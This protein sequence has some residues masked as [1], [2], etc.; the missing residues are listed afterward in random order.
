MKRFNYSLG[1]AASAWLLAILVIVA[2]LAEPFKTFLK[3][4]FSHHWIG[5]AVIIF[6]AFALFGFLLRDK[7]AI[8][9]IPAEK[10]AWYSLLGSLGV[11]LL[12][13]VIEFLRG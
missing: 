7:D 4:T 11:I 10:L 3:D 8:R 1:A 9:K 13:F 12:F 6:L 2:E 5:K